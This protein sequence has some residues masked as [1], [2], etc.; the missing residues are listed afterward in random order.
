MSINHITLMGTIARGPEFRMTPNG[1]PTASFSVAVV[2]PPRQEGGHEVTDYVRVVTWRALAERVRD[3]VVKD[4]L[5]TIEGRLTTRSYETQDGQRR[6]TIEVEASAVD[7]VRMG[8]KSA[9]TGRS[10]SEG[11]TDEEWGAPPDDDFRDLEEA[12]PPPAARP[13]AARPAAPRPPA[14]VS[15]PPDLDDE[16]PF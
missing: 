5:V 1:I 14:P 13:A 4:D 8:A 11:P 2:R 6:K 12:A 7:A 9:P 16:I 15:P 3:M 10:A